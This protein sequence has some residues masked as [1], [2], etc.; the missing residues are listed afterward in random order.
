MRAVAARP[1]GGLRGPGGGGGAA[2]GR[3][4]RGVVH[5][6]AAGPV[7]GR[8]DRR[9]GLHGR[10]WHRAAGAGRG[11]GPGRD[12]WTGAARGRAAA[13][14]GRD[15]GRRDRSAGAAEQPVHRRRARVRRC[16]SRPRASPSTRCATSPSRSPSR[17]CSPWPGRSRWPWLGVV[18][19]LGE[20]RLPRFG[21][22][23]S[24]GAARPAE[25]DPDRAA[26]QDLDAGRDPTTDPDSTLDPS[27]DPSPDRPRRRSPSRRARG[28]GLAWFRRHICS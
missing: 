11:G 13:G 14:R 4:G 18:V 26:W 25:L 9:P 6:R 2:L 20:P 21:A 3:L 17:R 24:T 19:L 16:R 27:L 10:G 1:L 12:G 15:R 8:A 22:R 5:R 23:Y 28:H 7:A